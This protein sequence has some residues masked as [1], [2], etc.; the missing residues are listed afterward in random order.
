[1]KT[2]L[3]KDS[4]SLK[5]LKTEFNAHFPH[6]KIEFFSVDHGEEEASPRTA[7]FDDKLLLKDIRTVHNEGELSIDGHLK[8]STFE[9]NF[10]DT[11]GI[12]AQ[13][14][15][16]SGRIWLQTVTTDDWTLA[17]QERKGLGMESI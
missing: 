2:L 6:L 17:D 14:Y 16:K 12:N 3:I 9:Q 15:R 7:I 11:F 10:H 4:K 13:V 8:T 1:M 5:E